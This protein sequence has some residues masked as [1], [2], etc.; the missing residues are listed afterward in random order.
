MTGRNSAVS[1]A[2]P[3]KPPSRSNAPHPTTRKRPRET[4]RPFAPR[5]AFAVIARASISFRDLNDVVPD[6]V[7]AHEGGNLFC[8]R[9]PMTIKNDANLVSLDDHIAF[10]SFCVCHFELGQKKYLECAPTGA[11]LH[12]GSWS[13]GRSA[14]P[15]CGASS[16]S[17]S[18][19]DQARFPRPRNR[20]CGRTAGC[21]GGAIHGGGLGRGSLP[22]AKLPP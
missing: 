2:S 7:R 1:S 8:D 3:P 22:S 4:L 10:G 5:L 13:A 19:Q 16:V 18:Q 14:M 9:L 6:T 11:G 15:S 20:R 21:S 17:R 12:V